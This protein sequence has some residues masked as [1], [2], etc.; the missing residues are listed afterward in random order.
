MILF[1]KKINSS[2]KVY[3]LKKDD[4]IFSMRENFL[5]ICYNSKVPQDNVMDYLNMLQKRINDIEGVIDHHFSM[6]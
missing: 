6:I 1:G 4:I 2:G 5:E 3:K